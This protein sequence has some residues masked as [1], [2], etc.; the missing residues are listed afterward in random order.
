MD[1]A[2]MAVFLEQTVYAVLAAGRRDGRPR[3]APIAFSIWDEAFWIA[4]VEGA[5]LRHLR[6]R[7]Y[8]SIVI[9]E[10]DGKSSICF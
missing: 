1:A 5:R 6:S 10:G 3:A 7:P 2:T 8:T 4:T 9:M